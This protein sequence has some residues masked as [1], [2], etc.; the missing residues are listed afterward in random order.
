MFRSIRWRT[1]TAFVVLILVS[2][3][4]LSLFVAHS[5]EG[6]YL[7]NL[8][9]QL[10]HQARLI[11]Y[12]SRSYFEA[13]QAEGLDALAK[14]LGKEIDARITIIDRSGVVL[15]DSYEDPAMMVNHSDRPEVIEC[16]SD[17]IGSSIRH[18]AT[19]GYDMMYVA[20]RI[21]MRGETIGVAR[22]ALPLTEIRES[23]SHINRTIAF[24]A[25]IAAVIAVVL[26]FQISRS[27]TDPVKKLTQ[28]SRRIAFGEFDQRIQVTS[29]DEVGELAEVFNLMAGRLKEIVAV[30]TNERDKMAAVLSAMSDGILAV[31]DRNKIV[32]VNR[33]A[34][35]LFRLSASDMLGR[36]FLEIVRDHELAGIVRECLETGEQRTG[37]VETER[38]TEFLRLIATPL[39]GGSLVLIQDI[40]ELRRL[41]TVRRDF[42]ANISHELRTPIASLKI[43]T[44]TLQDGA[45]DDEAVAQEFLH[46]ANIEVDRLTQMVNELAELSRIESGEFTPEVKPVDFGDIVRRVTER[47]G[48]QAERAGLKLKLDI[49]P[50]LPKGLADEGRLEQVLVNLLRNA[51]KFT[52][53]GGMVTISTKVQDSS[54]LVTV[55]DTGIGISADD[56]P[57]IFERFYKADRARA[58][59]GTGL[60]LAI[61]KHIV[62]AHGGNI[63]AESTEGS[64]SVFRFTVPTAARS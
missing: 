35:K 56:L 25:G 45:I 46:K 17:G 53:P 51:I 39:S 60:G 21:E 50:G 7:E 34:E 12:N 41:E 5:L 18:S 61:A 26:A 42:V 49:P 14:S 59:S 1:A 62:E 44:E 9:S 38:G 11:E 31:D 2:I 55:A 29:R 27:I 16:L 22:V 32:M 64:G 4:A 23:L 15:G 63:W 20:V 6:N 47:L 36:T 8:K 58:G 3:G 52:P 40:S 28:I 54:I 13:G 24:G 19:L 43:I 48:P 10:A 57:R 33:A 30:L 37:I